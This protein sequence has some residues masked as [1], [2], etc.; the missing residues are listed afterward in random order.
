MRLHPAPVAAVVLALLLSACP[1]HERFEKS[2]MLGGVEISAD[3][4]NRGAELYEARC[5]TCHG[6]A[7]AGD[8]PQAASLKARPR[9]LREGL[10]EFT[11]RAG[12][13]PTNGD[14]I[15]LI[16]HGL[17]GSMPATELSDVD[18]AAV[19]QYL[20]TLSPRWVHDAPA[21]ALR[22]SPKY[23]T[24]AARLAAVPLEQWVAMGDHLYHV[25]AN[26]W[27]CHPAYEPREYIYEQSY[28][29]TATFRSDLYSART[30][31]S[32]FGT[33]VKA[34]DFLTDTIKAGDSDEALYRTIAAGLGGVQM[35]G[36]A[37]ALDEPKIWALAYYVRSLI[38]QK[39]QHTSN[40]LRTRLESQS[41]WVP[42]Q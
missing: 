5:A 17:Q 26:C 19:G 37:P 36:S 10:F 31:P 23:V 15:R 1:K 38:D 30:L 35:P 29:R 13:L 14:L 21:P 9:D 3:Q 39:E 22:H 32:L 2:A 28:R 4:L 24:S 25:E 41:S 6:L 18:A 16:R 12:S 42:G 40:A 20:K 11:S 34:T 27:S 8:G 33:D 7:G